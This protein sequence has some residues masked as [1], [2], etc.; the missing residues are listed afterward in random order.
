MAKRVKVNGRVSWSEL[1]ERVQSKIR[2]EDETGCWE[3]TA[4][5]QRGYG[6]LRV[7]NPRRLV[8]AHRW[9]WEFFNEPIPDGYECHHECENRACVNPDHL[10]PMEAMEHQVKLSP[11]RRETHCFRGHP[12]DEANTYWTPSGWRCCRR[13]AAD[14][15]ARYRGDR[16]GTTD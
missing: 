6:A 10:H 13:C 7:S 1:P 14:R 15:A 3:W 8:R 12:F 9:V 2:V 11:A 16:H 4:A 5:K